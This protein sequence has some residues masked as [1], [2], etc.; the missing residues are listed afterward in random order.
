MFTMTKIAGASYASPVVAAPLLHMR[1][2]DNRETCVTTDIKYRSDHR[3][4]KA[5]LLRQRR[6]MSQCPTY[7]TL[8]LLSSEYFGV[9]FFPGVDVENTSVVNNCFRSGEADRWPRGE[10]RSLITGGVRRP[11]SVCRSR[12]PRWRVWDATFAAQRSEGNDSV[13]LPLVTQKQQDSGTTDTHKQLRTCHQI[14]S[15]YGRSLNR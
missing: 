12:G 14:V 3:P 7:F 13:K 1:K 8:L 15:L 10:V 11:R 9:V 6:E 5:V 2:R 4:R